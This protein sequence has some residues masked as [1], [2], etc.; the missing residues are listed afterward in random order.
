LF[1]LP[2]QSER[3]PKR[4]SEDLSKP[5]L[6]F[7]GAQPLRVTRYKVNEALIHPHK[8]VGLKID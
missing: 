8:K 5:G 3:R 2:Q 7:K 6:S 4:K 1:D